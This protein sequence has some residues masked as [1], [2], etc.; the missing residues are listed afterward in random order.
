LRYNSCT[1]WRWFDARRDSFLSRAE[2][3]KDE[4]VTRAAVGAASWGHVSR[5]SRR[6][7]TRPAHRHAANEWL[8]T[9]L[10]ERLIAHRRKKARKFEALAA[11]K[12]KGTVRT[13]PRRAERAAPARQQMDY[14]TGGTYVRG[15]HGYNRGVASCQQIEGT[16]AAARI[17][18]QSEFRNLD[19]HGTRAGQATSSGPGAVCARIAREGASSRSDWRHDPASTATSTPVAIK[20]GD[21]AC[22]MRVKLLLFLDVGGSN[23]RHVRVC[24]ELFYGGERRVQAPR[25]RIQFYLPNC[26]YET[27]GRTHG[28]G[29]SNRST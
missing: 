22:T 24:E 23:G 3:V 9:S 6:L 19:E 28:D 5:A 15:R 20:D 13:A 29:M 26:L 21:R 27:V 4:A 12:V 18:G 14:G 11:G 7:K 16:A 8:K 17:G 25:P 2:I 1:Q 10:G